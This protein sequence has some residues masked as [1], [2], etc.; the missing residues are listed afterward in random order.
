MVA[1]TCLPDWFVTLS[2]L[3]DTNLLNAF[4]IQGTVLGLQWWTKAPAI[5]EHTFCCK[6]DNKKKKN[7]QV[8]NTL[9]G[10]DRAMDKW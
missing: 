1:L 10:S 8:C 9:S 2:L 7:E 3:R 6:I 5:M 4:F